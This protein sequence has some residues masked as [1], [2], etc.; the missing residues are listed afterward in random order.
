MT[1]LLRIKSARTA[2]GIDYVDL[3]LSA[4]R[5]NALTPELLGAIETALDEIKKSSTQVAVLF[6]GKNFSSGGDVRRFFQATKNGS[7]HDYTN[8]LVPRLQTCVSKM[9]GQECLF[10][11]AATG[12]VTGGAAGFI[13]ASDV[14]V[15]GPTTFMQ[16]YYTEVGFAPDG[17]WTA[18]LPEMIG[19]QATRNWLQTN[20]R[21]TASELETMGIAQEVCSAPYERCIELID[22]LDLETLISCKSLLWDTIRRAQVQTRLDAETAAFSSLIVHP[23]TANKMACFLNEIKE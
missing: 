9:L 18:L 12:A 23:E 13:F 3:R 10:L 11:T 15:A 14:V 1:D 7:I 5:S 21:K 2:G 22:E 17:G 4:P 19:T 20:A 16:P 8:D 6:G